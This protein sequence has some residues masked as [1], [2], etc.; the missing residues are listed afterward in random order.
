MRYYKQQNQFYASNPQP[1][2]LVFFNFDKN[3]NDAEHIGIVEAVNGGIVVTIEGN[4]S[5][6]SN[7]NGGAVMRR[8][9]RANVILG[10]ARPAYEEEKARWIDVGGRWWYQHADGGFTKDDWEQ[11]GGAWYHFDKDGWMQT[12]WLE[13]D[14][15]WYYLKS[16]GRMA[17]NEVLTIDSPV[18]GAEIYA[19]GSDGRMLRTDDGSDRGNLL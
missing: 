12:G 8:E 4:T 10:Y 14:G 19:F 11:I 3:A 1:G 9:R 18:H 17:C 5:V 6:A 7:D 16:N 15:V 13:I 2:D